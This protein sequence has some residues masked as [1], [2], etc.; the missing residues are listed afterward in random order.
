MIN[1]D[2]PLNVERNNTYND[3]KLLDKKG[4]ILA[5]YKR[6]PSQCD[7][8]GNIDNNQIPLYF[9]DWRPYTESEITAYN[10]EV[11][12]KLK[13]KKASQEAKLIVMD[14]E[15]IINAKK[16]STVRNDSEPDYSIEEM[17]AL[18]ESLRGSLSDEEIQYYNDGQLN[19]E[20]D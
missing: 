20:D 3:Y 10:K 19:E 16:S 4:H 7:I 11:D 17:E 12:D 2:L 13:A 8:P 14:D 1:N 15:P 18:L 5:G 9:G 6:E